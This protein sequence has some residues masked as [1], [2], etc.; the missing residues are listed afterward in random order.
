MN[1]DINFGDKKLNEIIRNI[2]NNYE[3]FNF[4]TMSVITNNSIEYGI[5]DEDYEDSDQEVTIKL[6]FRY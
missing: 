6:K 3:K 5:E 2:K 1:I 4:C